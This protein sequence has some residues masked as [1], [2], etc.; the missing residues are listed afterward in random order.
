M[1]NKYT[2]NNYEKFRN[3]L[4]NYQEERKISCKELARK[5]GISEARIYGIRNKG[6]RPR[7]EEVIDLGN[8]MDLEDNQIAELLCAAGY[9]Q[10]VCF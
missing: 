10:Y 2:N 9:E 3:I 8:A 4:D 7:F 1:K 5:S 6:Y